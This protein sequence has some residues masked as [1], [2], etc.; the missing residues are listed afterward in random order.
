MHPR[1]KINAVDKNTGGRGQ[2]GVHSNGLVSPT[3]EEE[4]FYRKP[5]ITFATA[6]GPLGSNVDLI[7]Y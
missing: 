5:E 7:L 6:D 4:N 1:E 3:G 2:R